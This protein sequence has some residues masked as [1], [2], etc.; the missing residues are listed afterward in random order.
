[1]S[2]KQ[3]TI[4]L[5]FIFIISLLGCS[6]GY[7]DK[8][9]Y[10]GVA[11]NPQN[12]NPLIANDAASEKIN[13]L[14]YT[15]LFYYDEK[16]NLQSE[17]VSYKMLSPKEYVFTLKKDLPFFHHGKKMNLDDIMATFTH[18][19][20]EG[21]SSKASELKKVKKLKKL[22]PKQFKIY[23]NSSDLNFVHHLN[24][25]VLPSD[26]INQN[27]NF[28][29][30]PIGSGPFS[31]HPSIQNIKIKRVDDGQIVEFVEIK[32][33]TVRALKLI[34]NEIDI[35]QNDIPKETSKFLESN[36]TISIL[37]SVGSN[38][39]YLGFNF[40]DSWLGK[41]ELRR[42]MSLAINREQLIKFF[43]N[44]NT[45]LAEQ[46][47]PPEHWASKKI[48]PL[49]FNPILAREIVSKL[50]PDRPIEIT[51]KT[52]TDPFRLKIATII[53]EQLDDVG[54]HLKIKTL[55]WGT[56]FKDIQSG[57]FQ[58]YGLTW[59]G[60]K[61]PEIYHKI[62]HSSSTPPNGLNRGNFSSLL[63]DNLLEEA[64]LTNHWSKVIDQVHMQ[65][66]FIPLWYEGSIAALSKSISGYTI[67]SDGNW[68][69]LTT[70]KKNEF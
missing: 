35:I 44:E 4:T 28:S 63:L 24:F 19:I 20:D 32:D 16:S 37:K 40:N 70:I 42:A 3:Q 67:H 9:I 18:I 29:L 41:A 26:L 34:K 33:P 38:I 61:N 27:H 31:F 36:K 62:F 39:S 43:L 65:I 46:I 1:M 21:L 69:G 25:A 49:S 59:V 13:N 5:F 53:Q 68:N 14:I 15:S 55:D 58:M 30:N 22:S 10:F 54:I 51:F 56:Y 45:R 17:L 50:S 66:G 6:K 47:F 57:N 2:S 48:I 11:Q 60:V 52:S 23:L 7:D 8:I 64:R 12:L